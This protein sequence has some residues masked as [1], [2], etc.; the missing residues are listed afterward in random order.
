MEIR[1][2]IVTLLKTPTRECQQQNPQKYRVLRVDADLSGKHWQELQHLSN[3]DAL[4]ALPDRIPCAGCTGDEGSR[5]VEVKFSDHTKK[6][7]VL[8]SESL[9]NDIGML[10][11]KLGA[12]E[13]KLENE[14]PGSC[15]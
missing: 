7:V 11:E 15:D 3:H 6:S 4:F 8:G 1:P 12:L 2:G 9:P 5:L 13:S 14:L 10:L